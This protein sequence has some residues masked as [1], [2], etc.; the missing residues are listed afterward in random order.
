MKPELAGRRFKCKCGGV[1]AVP[2]EPAPEEE[3]DFDTLAGL[4]TGAET[5]E[6]PPLPPPTYAQPKPKRERSS[7][8]GGG[9]G[10][11][12][13]GG[14]AA[15]FSRERVPKSREQHHVQ[16]WFYTL[17]FVVGGIA[18]LVLCYLGQQKHEAFMKRAQKTTALV[19]KEPTIRKAGRRAGALNP[20]NWYYTFPVV[21][22]VDGQDVRHDVEVRGNSLPPNLN[23]DDTSTWVRQ[24]VT[25]YY[26][27]D[28]PANVKAA[29][30]AEASNWFWGNIIGGALIAIGAW[31]LV[32]KWPY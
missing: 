18:L 27:P 3:V 32:T 7:T 9:A 23:R 31:G 10:K 21:F 24:E 25:V 20:D 29:S 2:R 16:Y 8:S 15:I 4:G 13:K 6:P 19:A 14:F 28:N 11:W 5:N 22:K 30:A 1:I 17:G 12:L 26:D